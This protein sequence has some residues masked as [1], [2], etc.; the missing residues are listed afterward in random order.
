MVAAGIRRIGGFD[1]AA[2]DP[3]PD[4]TAT[5]FVATFDELRGD[6]FLL[7]AGEC[8]I[9]DNFLFFE[10]APLSMFGV[11]CGERI[12][13]WL[14]VLLLILF[15]NSLRVSS[16]GDSAGTATFGANSVSV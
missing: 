4:V 14:T 3:A 7:Y 8:R 2:E 11:S 16:L 6:D 5:D 13:E 12:F 1:E 10:L 15:W 9:C